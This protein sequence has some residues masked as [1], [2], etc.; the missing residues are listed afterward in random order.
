MKQKNLDNFRGKLHESAWKKGFPLRVMFELTYS[1]NF[2]CRHC[3]VPES[4][5]KDNE[6]RTEEVFAVLDQLK[7]TGCFYLGFTGGEPFV[8]KDI[9]DILWYAKRLGF[10]IIIYSNGSLIDDTIALELSKLRP[11]KVDITIPAMSAEACDNVTG[12][13][14][15]RDKIFNAINLLKSNDVGLGFKTC[16]LKANEKEIDDIKKFAAS[17]GALHRLDDSVSM[18]L[19]GSKEPLEYGRL[20]HPLRQSSGQASSGRTEYPVHPEQSRRV[21]RSDSETCTP[22]NDEEILFKCGVGRTQAA[23]TPF[24]ELKM[25]VMIDY[26]RYQIACHPDPEQSRRGRM[27]EN[28]KSAWNK[29]KNL[30]TDIEKERGFI[31][32]RQ[33]L[34]KEEN[35]CP[36]TLWLNNGKFYEDKS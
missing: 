15:S 1:C 10:E 34:D 11:N 12:L 4:F 28:L 21:S 36:A 5:K 14:G 31:Q 7:E 26:P 20:P 30:V 19:D 9:L 6:L 22:R 8:R 3:Y 24:G 2:S 18:R 25:C 16:L 32:N 27:T 29:L 23:I 33:E 17:L 13:K 35:W